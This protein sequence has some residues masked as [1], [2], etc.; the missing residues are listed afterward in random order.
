MVNT[1]AG[2]AGKM[3][4]A[5]SVQTPDETSKRSSKRSSASSNRAPR[6]LYLKK[7]DGLTQTATWV[8]NG[9]LLTELSIVNTGAWP[10]VENASFLSETLMPNVPEMY[11]LSPR[12]CLGIL[13]RA[14]ARG[15][16]LPEVLRIALE[17]QASA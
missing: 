14:S 11:F 6:C 1:P 9:P 4:P 10:N 3:S 13:R 7:A 5:H 16:E 12:A 17:R 15:K 8:T 2:S